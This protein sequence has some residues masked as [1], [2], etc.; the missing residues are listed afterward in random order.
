[1]SQLTRGQ[2]IMTYINAMQD[3]IRKDSNIQLKKENPEEFEKK[4]EENFGVLKEK[5]KAVYDKA[6]VELSVKDYNILK[7][8]LNRIDMMDKDNI[9]EYNA[10]AQ[11]GQELFNQYIKPMID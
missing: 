1:M 7:M 9:S 2:K 6:K 4:L 10:S 11:V 8:M 5:Y 3:F